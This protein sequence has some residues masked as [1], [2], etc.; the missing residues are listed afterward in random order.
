MEKLFENIKFNN[1][2]N[3]VIQSIKLIQFLIDMLKG[4]KTSENLIL[5]LKNF[6][7]RYDIVPLLMED[8][9][10][11]LNILPSNFSDNNIYEGIYP[12]HI[13]IEERLKL[14]F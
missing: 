11:Y 6:D 14:I 4:K 1:K 5:L 12:H 10:R 2:H 7:K 9:I 3:S 8:L 13:N